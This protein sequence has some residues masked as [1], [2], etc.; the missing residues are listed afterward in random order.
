MNVLRLP[1][2]ELPEIDF[3]K[4]MVVA[5]FMGERS[6]GGYE[7]EI[8]NII[9][10]EKQIAIEV[11]EEEPPPESLRTMVFTQPY[12]IVVIKRYSLPVVFQHP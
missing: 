2:P 10:T 12:H 5:I 4:E 8:I 3:E 1:R 7:I 9:K 6:S 11:E